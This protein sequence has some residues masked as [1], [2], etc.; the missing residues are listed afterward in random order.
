MSGW[1]GSSS[2][3]PS[4]STPP[5]RS[6]GVVGWALADHLEASLAIEA[7]DMALA[8][9]NPRPGLIHH[10]DRG[11][12][13]ACGAYV[14]KLERRKIAVSMSR[15]GNPNDHA[16]AESFMK[17]LKND[18]RCCAAVNPWEANAFGIPCSKRT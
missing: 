5:G 9:R 16:K 12:Q 15:P 11:V 6:P 4:F 18:T 13:Y 3:S 8:A 14:E 7:L 1:R 2:I 17:T 10:S